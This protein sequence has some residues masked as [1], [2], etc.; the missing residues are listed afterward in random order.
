MRSAVAIVFAVLAG[1]LLSAAPC[2]ARTLPDVGATDFEQAVPA[3]SF[4]AP[5]LA[6]AAGDGWLTS[7][8]LRAP[9]RFDLLGIRWGGAGA[10]V[11]LRVRRAEG[12]WSRWIEAPGAE[13]PPARRTGA[14]HSAGPVWTGGG[15]RYQLRAT[16]PLRHARMH[17]VAVARTP[18]AVVA[19]SAAGGRPAI[20]PRSA[21]DP[22]NQCRP[23]ITPIYGRVDFGMVH[24]TVSLNGYGPSSTPAMVL[25]ICLFH[26]NGNGWNDIGYNLLV[27]RYGTVFEGRAG[28]VD[29]PVIGAQAQGWNSVSTGVAAIGTFSG[30]APPSAALHSIARVLAWKLGLAGVPATGAIGEVSIGGELNRYREGAH[31]SFQR[32]S[33]HRDGDTTECPGSALLAQLPSLRMLTA[34]LL[35]T[36]RDLLTISPAV[37]VQPAGGVQLTGRLARAD[38]SRPSGRAVVLQQLL[39][40][41]W[42]DVASVAT[43]TDGIWLAELPLSVSGKVRA[44]ATTS[45]ITS[46]A[47]PIVVRAGVRARLSSRRAHPGATVELTGMTTP[48]KARVRVLV[49][50]RVDDGSGPG[51]RPRFAQVRLRVLPTVEGRFSAPLRLSEAGSYRVTVRTPTDRVNAAGESRRLTLV[52]ARG[53]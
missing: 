3:V 50:R 35:P 45:G 20:V 42:T 23:R 48:P 37:A 10:R 40:G 31:V 7:A 53:R 17:F 18:P 11:E 36:P 24:H 28:G 25:G 13:Q 43:E 15:T 4:G 27:D 8:P 34:Q 33:G 52:V 46:P 16:A 14:T 41:V 21:W 29:A 30:S 51:G 44:V 22:H 26:R 39:D 1:S 32:L 5:D 2:V 12:R 38:G 49:E 9:R 19:R 6:R 47:V